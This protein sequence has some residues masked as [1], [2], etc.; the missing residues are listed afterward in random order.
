MDWK[1]GKIIK[2]SSQAQKTK[3]LPISTPFPQFLPEF[4]KTKNKSSISIGKTV[5]CH[6]NVNC[7]GLYKC[8]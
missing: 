2:Y 7:Y 3:V 6:C 8:N 1:L 4:N 5:S